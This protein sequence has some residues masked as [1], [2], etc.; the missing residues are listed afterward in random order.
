MV[1]GRMCGVIPLYL[2]GLAGPAG[3]TGSVIPVVILLGGI[4]W[5]F[6]IHANLRWRCGPLE[7][8][9]S[10]PHFHHWHHTIDAPLS[11]N[12]ASMLPVLDRLF[13]Q[14]GESHNELTAVA[15]AVARG[16]D[17]PTV[18]LHQTLRQ[19]QTDA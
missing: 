16:R 13:G 8:V 11:H 18:E 2:L 14:R 15:D 1:F 9:L 6:F 3:V 4:V 7:W 17:R 10:T 5:G 19:C 12:Y